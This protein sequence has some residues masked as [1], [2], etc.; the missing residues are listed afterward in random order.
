MGATRVRV[1]AHLRARSACEEMDGFPDAVVA[2]GAVGS[3]TALELRKTGLPRAAYLLD[4]VSVGASSERMGLGAAG[5]AL[6]AV[7]RAGRPGCVLC[8]G[9]GGASG[10]E[11][12]FATL[13][14]TAVRGLFEAAEA[15]AAA[16]ETV[17]A[18]SYVQLSG[19]GAYDL[20]SPSSTPLELRDTP[21]GGADGL[22]Q[23]LP[24]AFEQ[25]V[26]SAADCLDLIA[27]A[28]EFRGVMLARQGATVAETHVVVSLSVR[29]SPRRERRGGDSA[30]STPKAASAGAG[31]ATQQQQQQRTTNTTLALVNLAAEERSGKSLAALQ[32]VLAARAAGAPPPTAVDAPASMLTTALAGMLVPSAATTV[33]VCVAPSA[34]DEDASAAALAFAAACMGRPAEQASLD[35]VQAQQQADG[36]GA[37]QQEGQAASSSL[38]QAPPLPTQQRQD[39]MMDDELT[40]ATASLG[41][42]NAATKAREARATKAE[43]HAA[44]ENGDAGKPATLVSTAAAALP[45]AP[46]ISP[47]ISPSEATPASA[48]SQHGDAASVVSASEAK[49]VISQ[50]SA[51][52]P[53]S[54]SG[55]ML[56]HASTAEE[57]A[58][59]PSDGASKDAGSGA[60]NVFDDLDDDIFDDQPDGG[61]N[62]PATAPSAEAVAA[63][64]ERNAQLELDLEALRDELESV[65]GGGGGSSE[66]GGASGGASSQR[67]APAGDASGSEAA[68]RRPASAGGGRMGDRDSDRVASRR[69]LR[70]LRS[71]LAEAES[72]L[73]S[74]GRRHERELR[75]LKEGFRSALAARDTE[76]AEVTGALEHFEERSASALD[77][78][79]RSADELQ[80]SL[81]QER[82]A[83]ERTR[84]QLAVLTQVALGAGGAGAGR[85]KGGKGLAFGSPAQGGRR[86]TMGG[87]GH[88]DKGKGGALTEAAL[89]GLVA[90]T[91]DRTEGLAQATEE[92]RNIINMLSQEGETLKAKLAQTASVLERVGVDTLLGLLCSE[93]EDL[94]TRRSVAKALANLCA[95][96]ESA[97][98]VLRAKGVAALSGLLDDGGD[99][100]V[101][102]LAAG[103]LANLAMFP[104]GRAGMAGGGALPALC[105]AA[106]SSADA[107][108][109]RMVAGALANLAGGEGTG[110]VE[111]R[112]RLLEGGGLRALVA[113]ASS[114]HPDV[115]AQVA[116]GLANFVVGEEGKSAEE[117]NDDGPSDATAV[118]A[119]AVATPRGGWP[120]D[121]LM[122][123]GALPTLVAM[124][125]SHTISVKRHAALALYHLVAKGGA[126]AAARL[127]GAGALEPLVEMRRCE[128]PDVAKLAERAVG[129]LGDADASVRERVRLLERPVPTIDE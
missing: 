34:A 109:L 112:A 83:H 97:E 74:A 72:A 69:A 88:K 41:A 73:A 4:A 128:R 86:G 10:K 89:Q 16:M 82:A 129:A 87:A 8:A 54:S 127:V 71:R 79:G 62:P 80:R 125:S 24:G 27:A 107:H 58:G 118:A 126:P 93:A 122:H 23:G 22:A 3:A 114:G 100:A 33:I 120:G 52:A 81:Q 53:P 56:E 123:A 65:R 110:A 19:G 61:A 67:S 29:R 32:G 13:C 94:P 14:D 11:E 101:R 77:A 55:T 121:A 49:S 59:A 5:E 68:R 91:E 28:N 35:R 105:V 2:V 48:A 84:R 85:S 104:K 44:A 76:L 20:L 25:Q 21:G 17:L 92:Y 108:V 119:A 70:S 15:D 95:K 39:S 9:R 66:G 40:S 111:A 124:A 37:H 57:S 75:E 102:R 115:L 38:A 50:K 12:A 31:G 26:S 42:A 103:A 7:L 30:P 63:V 6:E 36:G 106:Y 78:D 43:A 99:A 51:G 18:L 60:A 90:D 64:L 98:D 116:R 113:L 45:A 47:P 46:P 1:V 96:E 117:G